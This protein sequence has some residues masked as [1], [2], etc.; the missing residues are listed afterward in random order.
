MS[1]PGRRPG[2]PCFGSGPTAKRPGWSVAALER[3]LVGR[4]HR[5]PEARARLGEV[6]AR[7]RRLLGLPDDYRD[8]PRA[9]LR[10][11]RLRDG[12]VEPARR[13][14][15][16]R[17]RVRE[18]RP[19]LA[20]RRRLAAQDRGSP[21]AA[22]RLWRAAAA[23]ARPGARPGVHLER[24]HLG[25]AGAGRR[26]DRGRARRPHLVRCDLGRVR[27]GAALGQARRH[28]LLL[29]EGAGRRGPARH[30]DPLPARGRAPRELAPAL[31]AAEAP[32]PDCQGQAD[33]GHLSRRDDQH[34]LDA[35]GRGR[36]RRARLGRAQRRAGGA[37]RAQRRQSR[38][39]RGLGRAHPLDRRS[40]PAAARSAP[41]PRSA[42]RSSIRRS[43]ACRP[44]VRRPSSRA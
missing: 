23:R 28:H 21:P 8:R 15:R 12:A 14:R 25:R 34:A 19:G 43:P 27:D 44:S 26:L 20:E 17:D 39:D 6:L 1:R 18:L 22:G 38:G 24:H 35:G 31:A 37:D 33:R 11:R 41:R 7:S 3:A 29:A 16:R 4:S 40:S 9:G 2:N 36:A 10:Y 42:S 5:A 32:A 30:A 13:A